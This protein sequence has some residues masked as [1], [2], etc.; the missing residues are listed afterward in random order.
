MM[1]R[2][3]R[4]GG[5]SGAAAVGIFFVYNTGRTTMYSIPYEFSVRL[6]ESIFC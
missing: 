3:P 6:W 2:V 4:T 5:L 1:L